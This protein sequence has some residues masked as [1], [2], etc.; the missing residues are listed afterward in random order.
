M[1]ASKPTICRPIR[2]TQ[3]DKF[4]VHI[5]KHFFTQAVKEVLRVEIEPNNLLMRSKGALRKSLEKMVVFVSKFN[6]FVVYQQPSC[7]PKRAQFQ[8]L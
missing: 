3:R 1:S 7:E 5:A 6:R 2:R 4:G 8:A